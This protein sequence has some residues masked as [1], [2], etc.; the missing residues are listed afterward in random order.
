[1]ASIHPAGAANTLQ[2]SVAAKKAHTTAVSAPKPFY[3]P[4][5]PR[6]L[7]NA[8]GKACKTKAGAKAQPQKKQHKPAAKA[9]KPSVAPAPI[10]IP[11]GPFAPLCPLA[12]DDTEGELT[13]CPPAQPSDDGVAADQPAQDA[14]A[15]QATTDQ[16]TT[17]Q[18][19][20][21]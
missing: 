9:Q 14:G 2:C 5:N 17:D 19:T 18:P 11:A 15:D 3:S 1:G 4:L 20:T 10:V 16:P 21:D 8:G 13:V 12:P 6:A 7:L